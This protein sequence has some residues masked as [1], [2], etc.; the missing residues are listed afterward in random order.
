MAQMAAASGNLTLDENQPVDAD[1]IIAIKKKVA[2]NDGDLITFGY[3]L[4]GMSNVE[5]QGIN[6]DNPLRMIDHKFANICYKWMD[7]EGDDATIGKLLA[8]LKSIGMDGK[9]KPILAG[10]SQLR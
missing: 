2:T 10:L 5:V 7:M 1:H 8:A 3:K 4:L 9:A 6:S